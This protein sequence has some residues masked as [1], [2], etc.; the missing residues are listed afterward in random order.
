MGD[1]GGRE[2]GVDQEGG[3]QKGLQTWSG[4]GAKD[5]WVM[6]RSSN[7]I[8]DRSPLRVRCRRA[9]CFSVHTTLSGNASQSPMRPCFC[10]LVPPCTCDLAS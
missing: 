7:L 5:P 10:D 6:D 2:E 1:E 9:I 8:A 3:R 4:T